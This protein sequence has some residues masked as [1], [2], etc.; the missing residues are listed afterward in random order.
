MMESAFDLGESDFARVGANRGCPLRGTRLSLAALTR[1]L[2]WRV[3][4]KIPD[5][6]PEGR[7]KLN[8]AAPR[9]L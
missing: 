7:V 5:S 1:H 4:D 2:H 3:S 8:H 6:V 9:N